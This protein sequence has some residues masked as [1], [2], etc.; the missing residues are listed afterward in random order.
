MCRAVF[1]SIQS[2]ALK[3]LIS[4]AILVSKSVVSKRVIWPMPETPSTMFDQT[5]SRSLPIGV[6]KPIPVTATRR[7]LWLDAMVASI[8]TKRPTGSFVEWQNDPVDLDSGSK[9]DLEQFLQVQG[10]LK[11][12]AGGGNIQV[13]AEQVF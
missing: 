11:A 4:P 2:S 9:F 5:V 10:E 12:Q 7:P 1:L 13:A 6:M 8:R 3:P